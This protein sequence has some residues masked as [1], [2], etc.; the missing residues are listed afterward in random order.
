MY[1]TN[2]P[3]CPA[4]VFVGST[5][6]VSMRLYRSSEVESVRN[7]TRPYVTMHGEPVA[8]GW[9]GMRAIG[10]NDL[11]DFDFGDAPITNEGLEVVQSVEE[12]NVDGLV[13]VFWGCG[14]TP[15]EAVM[16]AKIP[17]TVMGHAPGYMVVMDGKGSVVLMGV[18]ELTCC[19]STRA[20]CTRKSEMTTVGIC[21][22]YQI[23]AS[24]EQYHISISE[25]V[26]VLSQICNDNL[27]FEDSPSSRECAMV[28]L[29]VLSGS[30]RRA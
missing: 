17:G 10:I 24:S 5:Y 6:V 18:I 1:R 21:E 19:S 30:S 13:P 2:I 8:W 4:G 14:V 12:A 27:T 26:V 11:Y 29:R 16:K 20:G 7:I 28:S 3:L 23:Q 25:L 15:Q 9:D 22:I